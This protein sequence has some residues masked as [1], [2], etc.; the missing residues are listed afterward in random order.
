MISSSQLPISCEDDPGKLSVPV[1]SIQLWNS[2]PDGELHVLAWSATWEY[3]VTT[4]HNRFEYNYRNSN[5]FHTAGSLEHKFTMAESI[6]I[7]FQ[8]SIFSIC[9]A[10]TSFQW[11]RQ[12]QPHRISCKERIF[13]SYVKWTFDRSSTLRLVFREQGS[14]MKKFVLKF[15]YF[16]WIWILHLK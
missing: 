7:T 1:L 9:R 5:R 15:G 6:N 12:V 13:I 16:V 8:G 3:Y 10:Q 4:K 11:P 14:L 2:S